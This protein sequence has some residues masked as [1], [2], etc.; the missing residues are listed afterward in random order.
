[1]TGHHAISTPV[2]AGDVMFHGAGVGR[3][4]DSVVMVKTAAGSW[5]QHG[6]C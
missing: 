3:N 1:M 4:S 6:Q 2:E 5:S